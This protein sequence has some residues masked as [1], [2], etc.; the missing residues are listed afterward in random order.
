MKNNI[1][2][3]RADGRRHN[4]MRPVAIHRG[5]T[6]YAE[7]SVLIEIGDTHVLCNASVDGQVPD[8]LEGSGKGWVTAEYSMLPRST[9]TRSSRGSSG[10]SSEIQRLIG[11]S[12]RTVVDLSKMGARTIRIDCDVL[13]ADGGTRTAAITGAL[14]ALH[15][16]FSLLLQKD[17]I[18]SMPIREFV[19]ATSV[20]MID[21]V[22]MLDLC[23]EEDSSA[24]VDLNA[25]MTGSGKIIEIQGTAEREPFEKEDLAEMLDLA[26]DG[27]KQLLEMQSS[28]LGLRSAAS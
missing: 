18:P 14:V 20:G 12:L 27:I 23:Y 6:K 3:I 13:Q 26:H 19:A 28:A 25:I 17:E 22:P 4:E 24:E 5:Y 9:H 11:R 1:E 21:G 7:G 10:R 2:I 15:D 8:F 16:A